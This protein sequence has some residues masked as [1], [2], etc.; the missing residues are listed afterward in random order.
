LDRPLFLCR[1]SFQIFVDEQNDERFWSLLIDLLQ[2]NFFLLSRIH[3]F[4]IH[5]FLIQS[6]QKIRITVVTWL[7]VGDTR[8]RVL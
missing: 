2:K 1:H 6:I 7:V 3:C 5:I 4:E 8:Y